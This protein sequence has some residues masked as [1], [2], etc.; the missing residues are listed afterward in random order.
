MTT[1]YEVT[2]QTIERYGKTLFGSRIADGGLQ[3]FGSSTAPQ[4]CN[5][6]I[7]TIFF[8]LDNTLIPTRKG[9]AKACSKIA[10]LLHNEHG[11]PRE[12]ATESS[13]T[14][15]ASYRRCPDNPDVP[16]TQW[17]TQMWK[18]AL[19]VSHKH[20]ALQLYSRWTDYR[21]RY[22]A[23]SADIISM[24]QTLR[25]RYL[26]GIISNGSS[27]G[28]W[29]KID[30]L[31]LSRFFDCILVSADL[32]WAKPDRNIFNA[33]CH[34]L[35]VQPE[36]CA[37]IGDKLETDV[38]GGVESKMGATIWLPL[39]K[40]LQLMHDKTL[41]DLD[42][43]IRPDFVVENVLDLLS[44]LPQSTGGSIRQQ[45]PPEARRGS[46]SFVQK[47]TRN[48]EASYNRFLPEVPDLCSSS[49]N[50]CDSTSS[51]ESN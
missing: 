49:S 31:A 42:E 51:M 10:D 5:K 50:S 44:V 11:L 4:R 37:M 33:A 18:D 14:F 32:P 24:L 7:T 25:H 9:D 48:R 35:G 29:E 45:R 22:L 39:P 21:T 3:L 43:H 38:Q 16:L 30:R 23:P 26:L 36:E 20:L 8:D 27:A 1:K 40:D 47:T 28:Q 17:R 15:L 34:Y 12:L 46:S 41:D 19:P 13:T 6:P 2:K